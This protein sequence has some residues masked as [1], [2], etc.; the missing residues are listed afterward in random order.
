MRS[1]SFLGRMLVSFSW[2]F[3]LV[4]FL[5]GFSC[6]VFRGEQ[7]TNR[8]VFVIDEICFFSCGF[9]WTGGFSTEIISSVTPHL[10]EQKYSQ[11][12]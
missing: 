3:F 12:L 6:W 8:R 7:F 11:S 1:V 2:W 5:G 9:S 4:G 10:F